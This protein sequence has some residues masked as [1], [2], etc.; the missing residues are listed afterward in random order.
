[1]SEELI[2]KEMWNVRRIPWN[3]DF[4]IGPSLQEYLPKLEFR[5]SCWRWD[6]NTLGHLYKV[7]S[8]FQGDFMSNSITFPLSTDSSE[9]HF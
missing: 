1:M 5:S 3:I 2:N 8:P 9:N 7:E 6:I 4:I